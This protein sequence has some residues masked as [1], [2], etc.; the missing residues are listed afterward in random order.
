MGGTHNNLLLL[1]AETV[2]IYPVNQISMV[3]IC[4]DGKQI[5]SAASEQHVM[6]ELTL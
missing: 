3:H 6:P 4:L 5:A 1:T 2:P